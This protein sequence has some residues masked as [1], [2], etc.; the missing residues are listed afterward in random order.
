MSTSTNALTRRLGGNEGRIVYHC[1]MATK[2]LTEAERLIDEQMLALLE[3]A[4]KYPMRWHD[5]GKIEE[6][7]KAAAQLEKRGAIVIAQPQNQYRL[8]RVTTK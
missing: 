7:Q 4:A 2:K 5:I 1:T 6:T 3:W 8:K